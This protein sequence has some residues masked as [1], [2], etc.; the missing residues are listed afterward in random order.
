MFRSKKKK[1]MKLLKKKKEQETLLKYIQVMDKSIQLHSKI[2]R[3]NAFEGFYEEHEKRIPQEE[4]LEKAAEDLGI[5][6][7]KRVV[8]KKLEEFIE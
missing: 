4:L 8:E 3:I 6:R 5:A 1:S 7:E 2:K